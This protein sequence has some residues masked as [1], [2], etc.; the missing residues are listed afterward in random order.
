MLKQFFSALIR[1]RPQDNKNRKTTSVYRGRISAPVRVQSG[2][3]PNATLRSGFSLL[4]TFGMLIVLA[5]V[6]AGGYYMGSAHHYSA[7]SDLANKESGKPVSVD[8]SPYWKVWT[9]LDEKYVPTNSVGTSTTATTTTAQD[10][11]WSSIEGLAKAYGDPYTVF[12]PPHENEVFNSSIKGDF[13]GVGME[14]GIHDGVLTVV[15]PLKDSPAQKAG[16]LPGDKVL[17]ID[18]LPTTD[19]TVEEAVTHIRGPKGTTVKLT[20]YRKDEKAPRVI[21]VVRD[22]INIPTINP[23]TIGDGANKVFVISLYSFTQNSPDLFH[24]ALVEFTHSGANKMVIDLR[25]DPGG[26][27]DAA[28]DMASYFLPEGKVV[29]R[30]YFGPGK[31]EDIHR[32]KGYPLF[33]SIPKVA[34]LV[35]GGSASASEILAGAL[36]EQGVAKL[37][38]EKTFGKGSVQEL[39][40]ITDDTALKVTIARWLTPNGNSIS[41]SGIE[42]DVKVEMTQ[43]DADAGKDPQLDAAV[44]LL[45]Q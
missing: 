44:K 11:V 26:Y 1:V 9:I 20:I 28:V 35:N 23:K 5:L 13:E 24:D 22:V 39:V 38:G 21:S 36:S 15:A 16:L 17:Q 33:T 43:K 27:L 18:D 29:V 30:E 41:K 10:R 7:V 32:S 14:I 12:L 31:D 8:F 2:G 25:G 34:I 6:Y 45:T 42:P 40:Q 4:G 19:M 3:M 37:V